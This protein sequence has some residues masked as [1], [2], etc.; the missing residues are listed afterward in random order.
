MSEQ[1]EKA[2]KIALQ[3]KALFLALC[4]FFKELLNAFLKILGISVGVLLILV[5]LGVGYQLSMYEVIDASVS[6]R[7]VVP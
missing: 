3:I 4:L 6:L 7:N 1:D 5:I 2:A